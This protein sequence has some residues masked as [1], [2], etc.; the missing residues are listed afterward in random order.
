MIVF[1]E[2]VHISINSLICCKCRKQ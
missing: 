2:H 1:K